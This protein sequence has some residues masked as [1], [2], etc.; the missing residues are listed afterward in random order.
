MAEI[1]P[2]GIPS[3]K[4]SSNAETSSLIDI[5]EKDIYPDDRSYPKKLNASADKK[6]RVSKKKSQGDIDSHENEGGHTG[7]K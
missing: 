1:F 6:S 4:T 7:K 2:S 3:E 5:N